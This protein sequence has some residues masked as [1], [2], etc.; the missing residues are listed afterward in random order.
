LFNG[1]VIPI[2]VEYKD[3]ENDMIT[4]SSQVEW[5]ELVKSHQGT[6][7]NLWIKSKALNSSGTIPQA[8]DS[9]SHKHQEEMTQLEA[10]KKQQIELEEIAKLEAVK[11][12]QTEEALKKQRTEEA[13]KKQQKEL[14]E[15]A[16][17]AEFKK[18]QSEKHRICVE[19][20]KEMEKDIKVKEEQLSKKEEQNTKPSVPVLKKD[21]NNKFI[22]QYSSKLQTLFEAGF[23]DIERNLYLLI[24]F[25][26]NVESVIEKL[27]QLK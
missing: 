1:N 21:N 18:Q 11:K 23:T 20:L 22:K 4:I 6:L 9:E 8:Q 16:K 5:D 25:N 15:K 24:T 7:V 26:G 13:L 19:K 2:T 10:L 14:E 17:Q 27:L 12:Q 3:E